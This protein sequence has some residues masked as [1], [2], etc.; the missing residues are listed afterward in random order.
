[1]VTVK[2]YITTPDAVP[3]AALAELPEAITSSSIR[4]KRMKHDI[5]HWPDQVGWAGPPRQLASPGL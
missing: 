1:M 3:G 2:I 5:G 4:S